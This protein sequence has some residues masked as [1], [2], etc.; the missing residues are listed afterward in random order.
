MREVETVQPLASLPNFGRTVHSTRV[1]TTRQVRISSRFGGFP[2]FRSRSCRCSTIPRPTASSPLYEM[3]SGCRS[4]SVRPPPAGE[5]QAVSASS[6]RRRQH[7]RNRRPRWPLPV[8]GDAD[9]SGTADPSAR[10]PPREPRVHRRAF[11]PRSPCWP[12]SRRAPAAMPG[13][14]CV[15]GMVE[16]RHGCRA[17]ASSSRSPHPHEPPVACRARR[18]SSV[19]WFQSSSDMPVSAS[20]R[21]AMVAPNRSSSSSG[22]RRAGCAPSARSSLRC[23]Y[24]QWS[25]VDTSTSASG[26]A[27][28]CTID[29]VPMTWAVTSCTVQPGSGRRR[30]RHWTSGSAGEH[31][32]DRGH[33]TANRPPARRTCEVM[34]GSTKSL[35][36]RNEV[37]DGRRCEM[38]DADQ[39]MPLERRPS[40][41]VISRS[42]SR[43]AMS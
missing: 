4:W 42:A 16:R 29:S 25:S 26:V 28:P 11:R 14:P 9:R 43:L 38:T 22:S 31:R 27:T 35:T 24:G 10:A 6:R 5:Q 41:R 7:L 33:H 12:P 30:A 37:P 18:A 13:R 1:S 36:R 32:V 20:R 2:Q 40:S 17:P 3:A 21:W 19:I 15:G 34:H 23:H 39:V 8:D